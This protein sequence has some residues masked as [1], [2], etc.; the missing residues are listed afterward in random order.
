M[1]TLNPLQFHAVIFQHD[2]SPN[3]STELKQLLGDLGL[4]EMTTLEF[5]TFSSTESLFNTLFDLNTEAS[6]FLFFHSDQAFYCPKGSAKL[7]E[8]LR[9]YRG[10]Y[11]FGDNYPAGVIPECIDREILP[12]MK[13]LNTEKEVDFSRTC[14]YDLAHRDPNLFELENLYAPK[15]LSTFRLRFIPDNPQ[16]RNT[17]TQFENEIKAAGVNFPFPPFEKLS[18]QI[19]KIRNQLIQAPAWIDIQLTHARAFPCVYY[20]ALQSNA[21][22]DLQQIRAAIAGLK[23]E[24]LTPAVSLG[25]PGD[26]WEHPNLLEIAKDI[27]QAGCELFL[28]FPAYRLTELD[29]ETLKPFAQH[30]VHFI[31]HLDAMKEKTWSWIHPGAPSLRDSIRAVEK[32]ILQFPTETWVQLTKMNENFE[33]IPDLFSHFKPYTENILIQ[34]YNPYLGRL[35]ERRQEIM[36]PIEAIDC[37]HIKR[38]LTILPDGKLAMCK[39]DLQAEYSPGSID[40]IGSEALYN[41]RKNLLNMHCQGCNFCHNCDEFYTFNR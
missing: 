1:K 33:E 5:K 11:G 39:Q 35:K 20:P 19:L 36:K 31:V 24:G 37:W 4:G 17:C 7:L 12:I 27:V 21:R 41:E 25:G 14:F 6:H 28:E 40:S 9:K 2:S 22:L 3:Y 29:L 38:E 30:K 34:K 23:D 18:E 32:M 16:D 8:L 13:N 15:D 10:E 26:P